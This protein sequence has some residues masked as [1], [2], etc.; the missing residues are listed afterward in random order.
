MTVD[1]DRAK[2]D[3]APA[4]RPATWHKK[5]P[6]EWNFPQKSIMYLDILQDPPNSERPP[7]AA[8]TDPVPVY[9][10]W[11]QHIWVLPRLLPPIILHR[12]IFETTGLTFHP[13]FALLY[14]SISFLAFGVSLF[15]MLRR[16]GKKYGFVSD[17]E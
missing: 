2:F 16:M 9:P 7:I 1:I 6:S 15:R 14:Y 11:R 8:K 3:R 17:F 10:V 12:L 4:S 5:D 13:A